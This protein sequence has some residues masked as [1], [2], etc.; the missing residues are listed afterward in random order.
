VKLVVHITV[1][2]WAS[3]PF[4]LPPCIAI[5][6]N[7]Y[8]YTQ[9][10]F[11]LPWRIILVGRENQIQY[12]LDD[13]PRRTFLNVRFLFCLR[14]CQNANTTL[15]SAIADE[16]GNVV[17]VETYD[18]DEDQTLQKQS[19]CSQACGFATMQPGEIGIAR[20]EFKILEPSPSTNEPISDSSCTRG[21]INA[22]DAPLLV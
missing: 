20:T 1:A 9:W 11:W 6:A 10:L 14:L 17:R 2:R 12:L 8:G 3:D 18:I 5:V 19:S 15:F 7:S 22:S 21:N 4:M 16:F 13:A